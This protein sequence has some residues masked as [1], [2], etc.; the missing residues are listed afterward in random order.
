LW[1]TRLR[2]L[3]ARF[4]VWEIRV[5]KEEHLEMNGVVSEVLPIE[6]LPQE[7][8]CNARRTLSFVTA[9]P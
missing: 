8:S 1:R 7:P 5:A 6:R 2:R 3:A 9:T 4:S